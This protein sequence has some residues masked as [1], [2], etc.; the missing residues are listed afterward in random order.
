MSLKRSSDLM[1]PDEEKFS[2]SR[3]CLFRNTVKGFISRTPM[4]ILL[5]PSKHGGKA[6]EYFNFCLTT[7]ERRYRGVSFCKQHLHVLQ[8]VNGSEDTGIAF[9]NAIIKDNEIKCNVDTMLSKVAIT[10]VYNPSSAPVISVEELLSIA[11]LKQDVTV[12]C[13]VLQYTS[14]D[15]GKCV[16]HTYKLADETGVVKLISFDQLLSANKLP[17]EE[18]NVYVFEDVQ[19]HSFQNEKQ[20][21]YTVITL[22][23]QSEV[24]VQLN[25]DD[26]ETNNTFKVKVASIQKGF[27]TKKCEKC[28]EDIANDE[29]IYMCGKCS[30]VSVSCRQQI[31]E[32]LLVVIHENGTRQQLSYKN[33]DI[34]KDVGDVEKFTAKE[35]KVLLT[36]HFNITVE[37]TCVVS[38]SMM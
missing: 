37:G 33:P 18:N 11:Q 26:A 16:M 6:T 25:K 3:K 24:N 19:V 30:M 1:A 17:I 13:K 4:S 7:K 31:E 9:F 12:I 32:G 10:E 23:K 28:G 27:V 34:F 38:L 21:K 22:I 14:S 29:G 8:T 36:K 20:L 35:F 5:S 15:K 2:P